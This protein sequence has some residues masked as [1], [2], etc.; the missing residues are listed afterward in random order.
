VLLVGCLPMPSTARPLKYS[1]PY[2]PFF[3]VVHIVFGMI[4]GLI[5][6]ILGWF[7]FAVGIFLYIQFFLYELFEEQKTGDEMFYQLREFT[8]GYTVGL[9]L[10]LI[11]TKYLSITI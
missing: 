8:A 7:G 6:G 4:A 9:I 10:G 2:H 1:A 3:V 5:T 11:I